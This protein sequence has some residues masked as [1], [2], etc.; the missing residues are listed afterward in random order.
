MR[1]RCLILGYANSV[2]ATGDIVS[3]LE[4]VTVGFLPSLLLMNFQIADSSSGICM[5]EYPK[6]IPTKPPMPEKKLSILKSFS[7]TIS[8]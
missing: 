5:I 3:D 6:I 1:V 8:S 2:T 7:L 4:L